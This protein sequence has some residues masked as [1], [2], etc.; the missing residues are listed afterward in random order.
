MVFEKLKV[1]RMFWLGRL[2]LVVLDFKF[3]SDT[4]KYEF[5]VADNELFFEW[6]FCF[7]V[8]KNL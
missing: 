1:L 6:F 2:F 3:L 7:L 8:F 5:V 4:L